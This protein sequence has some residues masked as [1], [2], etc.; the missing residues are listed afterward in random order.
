VITTFVGRI[1]FGDSE[2]TDRKRKEMMG[3]AAGSALCLILA[4]ALAYVC[5]SHYHILFGLRSVITSFV[6]VFAVSLMTG[7]MVKINT[8][9]EL[10]K[11]DKA[12]SW[13]SIAG[14]ED[15]KDEIREAVF[16]YTDEATYK[17]IEEMNLSIVKGILFYGPTGVG[18]TLFAQVM[19][20]E[21]KLNFIPVKCTDFISKWVGESEAQLKS[22]FNQ[23][24]SQTP[25]IIFFDEIEAFLSTR[26]S[27]SNSNMQTLVTTF[28]AEMDGFEK[29]KDVLVVG[30]TNYPN[31]IDSA[32]I[33]PGRF[34]KIIYI[35]HP[36][37]DARKKIF[38][39][40]LNEKPIT[41]K[42][43]FAGL[44]KN[45]ERYTPA[46]ICAIITEAYRA[47]NYTAV[48][49]NDLLNLLKHNKA[50]MTYKMLETYNEF[51]A[52]FGRRKFLENESDEKATRKMRWNQVAGM[53]EAKS[54]LR[55]YIEFPMKNP[56]VYKQLKIRQSKGILLFGPPG[57]GKTHLVQVL[58]DECNVTFIPVKCTEILRAYT[59]Q[60]ESNIR[61][62]FRKAKENRP[63]LIFFDELDAFAEKRGSG[64]TKIVEQLLMEL[65]N[66]DEMK[67]VFVLGAT[68]RI[69][70][71]DEA[72]LRPGRFDKLIDI[73]LPD[74][75]A[76]RILL[77]LFLE[78]RPC[79]IDAEEAAR[80]TEGY[81]GAE[82]DYIVNR[83]AIL[84]AEDWING[85]A[86]HIQ[87]ADL[88]SAI[89]STPRSVTNA[90]IEEF[91][92]TSR[93]AR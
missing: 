2:A 24:R 92:S 8:Y 27:D 32:V 50:T 69:E 75:S 25:C 67:D 12:F 45:S 35:P 87:M 51:A 84:A 36:D 16:P 72:L 18:K 15:V 19:A 47:S 86:R 53:D 85:D 5:S 3:L 57:C 43:D 79:E 89:H 61:D 64:D 6:P 91:R 90:V 1:S 41:G 13:E 29:L 55:R 77:D 60:S 33:R 71:I 88:I 23:A 44:A 48:S 10:T 80:L 54:E 38:E 63:A 21:A 4:V 31:K 78:G 20:S 73:G 28:L 62:I 58:A 40:Y 30:A 22:I 66:T 17:R 76:R 9:S 56:D 70:V 39:L 11:T 7:S 49:N 52:R 68:N 83:A 93:M 14:Y 59:G 26:E 46:D 42:I 82:I 34:D 37:E 65:D 74:Q 81:T